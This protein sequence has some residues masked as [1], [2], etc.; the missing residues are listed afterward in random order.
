[1]KARAWGKP[2]FFK[3]KNHKLDFIK[4]KKIHTIKELKRHV[5]DRE[6][7]FANHMSYKGLVT[8]VF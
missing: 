1:M 8:S 3:K 4:I 7:T 2:L 6:K 5:P